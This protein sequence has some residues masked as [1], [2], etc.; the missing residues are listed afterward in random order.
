MS[1]KWALCGLVIL[2]VVVALGSGAPQPA[3]P[4]ITNSRSLANGVYAVLREGPTREEARTTERPNLVLV[5]DRKYSDADKDQPAKYVALETSSFVPLILA[6]P[7]QAHRD[8]NGWTLLNLTLARQHVKTLEDFSRAHLDGTV[9]IVID[10]EIIT[11]HKV[12]SV[13]KDGNVNITRCTD[14]ACRT[15]Y[16]K[17]AK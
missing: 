1:F 4:A 11:M 7:P 9:A 3:T 2:T 10:G 17:L 6:G 12:R 15:L 5:Y 14:D 13:I 16:L 8:E